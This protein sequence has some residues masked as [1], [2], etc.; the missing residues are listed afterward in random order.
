MKMNL[1]PSI[2]T[3][4]TLLREKG[5]KLKNI[6]VCLVEEE[7]RDY[8]MEEPITLYTPLLIAKDE[9]GIADSIGFIME[10]YTHRRTGVWNVGLRTV[11]DIWWTNNFVRVIEECGCGRRGLLTAFDA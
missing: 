2:S 3:V 1:R 9:D 7:Y 4:R 6:S 10:F 8:N 11:D 5:F